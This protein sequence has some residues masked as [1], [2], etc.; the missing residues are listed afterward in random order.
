MKGRILLSFVLAVLIPATGCVGPTG[1]VGSGHLATFESDASGFSRVDAS[2]SFEITVVQA[3]GYDV[4]V[5]CDDNIENYLI[6]K[7]NGDTLVLGLQEGRSYTNT[8]LRARVT[9]PECKGVELSGSSRA[10][11]TGFSSTRPMELRLSGSSTANLI[12][13]ECGDVEMNLSGSSDVEGQLIAR[14]VILDLSGSSKTN[15]EGSGRN[16]DA[17]CSGSSDI[18]IESF[19]VRK[20]DL[21][22]SGASTAWV[23]VEDELK[24]DLSGASRVVYYGDAKLVDVNLSGDSTV[25]R[26]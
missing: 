1:V 18:T 21:N 22:L 2:H 11:V 19:P 7:K 25:E 24:V 9:M 8:T 5:T 17:N 10:D 13:I 26:G 23:T 4:E 12:S 16:L 20:A 15:I 6:V 3:A 14:D